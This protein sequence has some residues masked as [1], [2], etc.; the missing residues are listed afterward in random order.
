MFGVEGLVLAGDR[1]E[2][3]GDR[4]ARLGDALPALGGFGRLDRLL[5]GLTAPAGQRY[6]IVIGRT[7]HRVA[8]G[9]RVVRRPFATRAATP[10]TSQAEEDEHR[11]RQKDDGVT[12]EDVWDALDRR[13]GNRGSVGSRQTGNLHKQRSVP[14]QYVSARPH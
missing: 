4:R 12:I 14:Y 6:H 11:Q 3:G 10:K 1:V 7:A 13:D 5:R 9:I 2:P 8:G